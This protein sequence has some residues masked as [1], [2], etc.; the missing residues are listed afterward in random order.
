[1]KDNNVNCKTRLIKKD[2]FCG[3]CGGK[4]DDK[5]LGNYEQHCAT[6]EWRYHKNKDL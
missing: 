6:C 4:P 3:C 2:I 1:M 5:N